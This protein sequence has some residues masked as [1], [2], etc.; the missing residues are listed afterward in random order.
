MV[1]VERSVI[2]NP[3]DDGSPLTKPVH[4]ELIRDVA[5]YARLAGIRREWLWQPLAD[6]VSANELNYISSYRRLRDRGVRGLLYIGASTGVN[7]R[8]QAMAGGLVRNFV[9]ARVRPT[10]QAITRIGP[11]EESP[12]AACS[13]LFL[14]DLCVGPGSQPDWFVREVTAMFMEREAAGKQT[15][16][17]I[18]SLK[19][20]KSVYGDT[21]AEMLAD[22]NRYKRIEVES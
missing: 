15:V 3:W 10:S 2:R 11:I 19:M 17:Y 20:V 18:R 7:D 5:M 21:L 16:S 14:P 8:M 1:Q 9:D 6:H 4:G 12:P 13:V 22:E